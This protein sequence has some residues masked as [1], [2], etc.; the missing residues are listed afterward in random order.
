MNTK[1]LCVMCGLLIG[2]GFGVAH[3]ENT[4][5]SPQAIVPN[6]QITLTDLGVDAPGILPTS[7]FYF[8][9][10]WKRSASIRFARQPMDKLTLELVYL[11]EKAAETKKLAMIAPRNSSNINIA[12]ANYEVSV[13]DLQS[14]LLLAG[15]GKDNTGAGY[16]LNQLL[17]VSIK[18][19]ELF[20][21]LK[22]QFAFDKNTISQIEHT[23]N[24]LARVVLGA[25]ERF[26]TPE[27][28]QNRLDTLRKGTE[29]KDD[30]LRTLVKTIQFENAIAPFEIEAS[31]DL[32][33]S[34]AN[35]RKDIF[36]QIQGAIASSTDEVRA[37]F[38]GTDFLKESESTSTSILATSTPEMRVGN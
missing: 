32:K 38:L 16:F 21:D 34:L 12:L 18:H 37:V 29:V 8:A 1:T 10:E 2:L 9:K 31:G 36:S 30:A 19:I 7:P 13:A 11:N 5:T 14:K 23:Q 4:T 22:V 25:A 26:D 33:D 6:V 3:A 17:S 28:F 35:F 24:T 27:N 15:G 20:N